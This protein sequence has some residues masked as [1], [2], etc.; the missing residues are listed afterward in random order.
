MI[1]KIFMNVFC[2]KNVIMTISPAWLTANIF[3]FI[4]TFVCR[5]HVLKNIE[6]ILTFLFPN[7][8]LLYVTTFS[9]N[10]KLI[11]YIKYKEIA[12]SLGHWSFQLKTILPS[13]IDHSPICQIDSAT[14]MS[15]CLLAPLVS[16]LCI[17]TFICSFTHHQT[18]NR[19]VA[20]GPV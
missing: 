15:H 16:Y 8:C 19:S 1:H 10:V 13:H 20:A 18:Q 12:W 7:D 9:R 3:C 14:T 2:Y 11:T 5:S 4:M 6:Y 17:S